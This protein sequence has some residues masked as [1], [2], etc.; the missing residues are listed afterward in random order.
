[1]IQWFPPS[2]Y[3]PRKQEGMIECFDNQKVLESF[4]DV[5]TAYFLNKDEIKSSVYSSIYSFLS[6]FF[7]IWHGLPQSM[8]PVLGWVIMML[9]PWALG[10][11]LHRD[12][13]WLEE[14]QVQ[15]KNCTV[16]DSDIHPIS[17][18]VSSRGTIPT[19]GPVTPRP[20][21]QI[22]FNVLREGTCQS[23]LPFL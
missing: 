11:P 9:A 16:Q 18:W 4:N 15:W 2:L 17:W 13:A 14:E 1:M 21:Q 5:V 20:S 8:R 10:W 3:N 22:C 19:G 7:E 12:Q 6:E 23:Q